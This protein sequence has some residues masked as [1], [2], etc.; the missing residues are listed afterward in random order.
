MTRY[1]LLSFLLAKGQQHCLLALFSCYILAVHFR[2]EIIPLRILSSYLLTSKLLIYY[3]S[4]RRHVGHIRGWLYKASFHQLLCLNTFSSS[5]YQWYFMHAHCS[6]GSINL[7]RCLCLAIRNR[8]FGEYYSNPG[9]FCSSTSGTCA[10]I[11]LKMTPFSPHNF[12]HFFC[13][14]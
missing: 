5:K 9:G 11:S 6:V 3:F 4:G 14:F 2:P 12:S 8:V 1:R 7:K 10:A 13:F